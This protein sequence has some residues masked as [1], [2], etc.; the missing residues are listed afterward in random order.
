MEINIEENK[1]ERYDHF[2]LGLVVGLFFPFFCFFL[3]W[4]FSYNYMDFPVKFVRFLLMM[5]NCA[6][7]VKLCTIANLIVFYLF[8]TKN[9]N[10]TVKGIIVSTLAY[11]ALYLYIT[12]YVEMALSS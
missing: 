3:Y 2:G 11:V 10:K 12:Y 5:N 8:L 6:N 7:V 9:K 1:V 4:L